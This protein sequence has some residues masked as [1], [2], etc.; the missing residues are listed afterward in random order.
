MRIITHWKILIPLL[1]LSLVS[2]AGSRLPPLVE[3]ARKADRHV[4]LAVLNQGSNVN[5]P[6]AD[7]TTAL[8]WASYLDDVESA[9]LLISA[10]ARVNA[11]NDLGASPLWAAS[12]NGSTVMVGRLLEA[13]A[14][15]NT[16]LL[17]GETPLMVASRSGFSNVVKQLLAKGANVDARAARGQTALMWAVA[18][19]HADVVQL[20][21]NSSADIHA[22]SEVWDQIMAVPPHG[23]SEYNRRIPHGGNT[24][25]LFAA[26]VGDLISAKLLVASGSNVND[27]NAWGVSVTVLAAHSGHQELVKFLLKKGADP[28]SAGAGFTALHEAI[29]RRDEKTVTSLLKH[30]ANPNI[31]LQVWTPIRRASRDWSFAPALVG[32]TPFWLAARLR[33]PTVMRLLVNYGANPLFVHYADYAVSAVAE[34]RKEVTTSLM[35]ALGMGG[36][37][38]GWVEPD[39]S[40]LESLTLETV[41]LTTKLGVDVNAGSTEGLTALDAAMAMEYDTVVK[42]LLERGARS[43]G[44]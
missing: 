27:V 41:K 26:R 18:Q 3:A 9:N 30:G 20:L 38:R 33:D 5:E 24:A 29:M 14:D 37:I 43:G 8:H 7:G 19:K 2:A 21:L 10:G 31:P 6:D 35:A 28:N 23:L 11:T 39:P 22:R 4:L 1:A 36:R 34:R 13:G 16:G 40:Q 17:L 25:L 32:A 44:Q 42:F 15:P 12:Q